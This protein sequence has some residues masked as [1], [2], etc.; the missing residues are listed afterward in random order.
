M[1]IFSLTIAKPPAT[2]VLMAHT[3][4]KLQVNSV[5]YEVEKATSWTGMVDGRC[6]TIKVEGC[7]HIRCKGNRVAD[8]CGKPTKAAV[9]EFIQEK[10]WGPNDFDRYGVLL[11]KS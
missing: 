4:M 7:Y 1:T 11:R 8:Y 6:Q 9:R 3:L 2:I 10:G 5:R